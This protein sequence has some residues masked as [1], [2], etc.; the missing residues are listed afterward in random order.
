MPPAAPHAASG[1]E[2]AA[3]GRART[4]LIVEDDA[5]MR[6]DAARGAGGRGLRASRR[7]AAAAR[8]SSACS[9]AGS[10]WSSPTSRCRTST[11][12]TCCA[13][14]RRSTP[15]A[16]R[17]HHHRVRID[18]HRHPRGEAGRVRLHHQAV[19]GRPADPVGREGARRA[20][21]ALARWRGCATR[22]QR[23]YRLE[24]HHRQVG[25]DAGRVR[26]DPPAVGLGGDRCSSRASRGPARSWS[27]KSL[28]FNSRARERPFVAV[29]CAAIP[30]TLLES[31]LFGYKRGA[32]TDARTDR[33]GLFVE[34]DGGT[35]LPR[36][37]RRAVA[38]A[39]G[40]AAARAAGG[41]DPPAGRGAQPRRSTCA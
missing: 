33:A 2:P 15:V 16:A 10:T 23:S 38:G 26:A 5:A 18:R 22:S 24:Q 4:I 41:R 27:R 17:H 21:A 7:S 14:S 28:H 3:G 1:P 6:D 19:R 8:A 29:N 12:W 37:D 36:R 31:E 11:A 30:D 39:A 40:Q 34:A 13:R 20:R 32:F 25:G 35:H 9:R